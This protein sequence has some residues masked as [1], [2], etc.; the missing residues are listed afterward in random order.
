MLQTFL[1]ESTVW[2]GPGKLEAESG[3]DAGET[4]T[5]NQRFISRPSA[6]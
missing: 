5:D 6:V 2:F 4:D 1:S 3:V